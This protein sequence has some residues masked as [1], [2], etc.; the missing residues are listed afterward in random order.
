MER[1]KVGI[2][3]LNRGGRHAYVAQFSPS[4]LVNAV[5]DLDAE[6]AARIAA[7]YHIPRAYSDY[8]EMLDQADID[9]VIIAT[10]IACH[11]DHA[12]MA[13]RA[14][15]H[16]LS[17]VTCAT[18]LEDLQR[19][20]AAVEASGRRYML[21]EN[22][23]WFRPLVIVRRMIQ[24]GLLGEIYYAEGDY[25]KDFEYYP[26][27]PHIGGWREPTYFGRRGH[28]YITHSLGPL[29]TIM[30]E[31]IAKVVC[32]GAGKH[33]RWRA[34]HT[35]A[36]MLET[37]KGHMI[38]LRNSFISPRPDNFLY[39]SFQGTK[40]CFQAAQGPTDYHKIHIQG[41]CRPN[42]WRN[43]DEFAGFLEADW[44]RLDG[45]KYDDISGYDSGTPLMQETFARCVLRGIQPPFALED[46]LN[47]TAT[48]LLS[49]DSIEQGAQ[50]VRVPSFR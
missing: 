16:V 11:V 2:V 29:A 36:L 15:K 46:A 33:E 39:Y 40:G 41:L 34:D 49:E 45:Q 14:G 4:I 31:R 19:L 27:Y 8:A 3:G 43:I 21:A 30:Q 44:Q 22:Y 50:P 5:C 38:R 37:E 13:L 12:V 28:P 6:K 18:K 32:M 48:G 20:K 24:E 9:A 1:L 23:V 35:C 10:P 7:E 47:W 42:E 25:L 17:E 26:N